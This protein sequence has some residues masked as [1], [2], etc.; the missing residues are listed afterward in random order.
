MKPHVYYYIK[1]HLDQKLFFKKNHLHV[2]GRVSVLSGIFLVL[3]LLASCSG[4]GSGGGSGVT[5]ATVNVS[6][7]V[8]G[9]M[10]PIPGSSVTLWEAGSGSVNPAQQVSQ[11]VMTG[12]DGSYSLV[13]SVP[14]PSSAFLYV[15][16]SGGNAEGTSNPNIMLMS[17]IGT[18]NNL[19]SS[20]Y[21]NEFTTAVSSYLFLFSSPKFNSSGFPSITGTSSALQSN[22]NM[23]SQYVSLQNGTLPSTLPS[24][25]S[26]QL[27][28]MANIIATCV[29]DS[30]TT[31]STCSELENATTTPSLT[32]S[33][34]LMGFANIVSNLGNISGINQA[35]LVSLA[36][37]PTSLSGGGSMTSL[38]NA[39]T[40]PP[41][42]SGSSG[43]GGTGGSGSGGGGSPTVVGSVVV[44][45]TPSGGGIQL[46]SF[47]YDAAGTITNGSSPSTLTIP[48]TGS[49]GCSG[50]ITNA[51][52][53]KTDHLLLLA[54]S[55]GSSSIIICSY[56]A[57]P[58]TG[59]ITLDSETPTLAGQGFGLDIPDRMII[60]GSAGSF[61]VYFYS[62]TGTFSQGTFNGT[63]PSPYSPFNADFPNRI[64]WYGSQSGTSGSGTQ[65]NTYE[66]ACS[67][68]ISGT[69][70]TLGSCTP[71]SSS[72]TI[73][74]NIVEIDSSNGLLFYTDPVPS[75]C[76]TT[77]VDAH[78]LTYSTTT[79][80][81]SNPSSPASEPIGT[82][83][84]WVYNPDQNNNSADLTEDV[85]FGNSYITGSY[86]MTPF[87]FNTSGTF[88]TSGSSLQVTDTINEGAMDRVNHLIFVLTG[89]NTSGVSTVTGI[90]SYP[91]SSSGFTSS[92]TSNALTFSNNTFTCTQGSNCIV[93]ILAIL[94]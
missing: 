7:K 75:N 83:E 25:S 28:S 71:Y 36:N 82:C 30:T 3:L 20:V 78:I 47:T 16:A 52:Y 79:G 37:T 68:S 60:G 11:P 5:G 43:G 55:A 48:A 58:T 18:A 59:Q 89:S 63:V 57:N 29:E 2:F 34:T 50:T 86:V 45:T 93:G 42:S 72:F 15:V 19:P 12:S 65:T 90:N 4:G 13:S 46:T 14:L 26:T 41:I 22:Q 27:T 77:A 92:G 44:A 94:H 53:D 32:P 10:N 66:G 84:Y 49:S 24:G 21:V 61:F 69:A 76:S 87:P 38:N 1:N 51:D 91:Y 88:G 67:F 56:T 6:G 64:L 80:V 62:T 70:M 40:L 9:G 73:P 81:F 31:F 23:M 74:N 17:T 8:Q 54:F 35:T 85:F 33:N 39:N